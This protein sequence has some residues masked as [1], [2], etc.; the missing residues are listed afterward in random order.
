MMK[1]VLGVT[2]YYDCSPDV[3][4]SDH[5]ALVNTP[6]YLPSFSGGEACLLLLGQA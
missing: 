2:N 1:S 5:S 4:Q 3:W 6:T